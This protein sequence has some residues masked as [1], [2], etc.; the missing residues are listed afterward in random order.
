MSDFAMIIQVLAELG[1]MLNKRPSSC[2]VLRDISTY[3]LIHKHPQLQ[4]P[5]AKRLPRIVRRFQPARIHP[6]ERFL[7][8]TLGV[9]GHMR[10]ETASR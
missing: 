9:I 5:F 2:I 3:T 4:Q 8:L 6:T 10:A 7:V 1:D